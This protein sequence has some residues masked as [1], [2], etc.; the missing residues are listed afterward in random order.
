V[1]DIN[2]KGL[3]LTSWVKVQ[4]VLTYDA[5]GAHIDVGTNHIRVNDV[6]SLSASD[7]IFV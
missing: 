6:T 7:F 2:V 3:G 5:A 4:A 1:D